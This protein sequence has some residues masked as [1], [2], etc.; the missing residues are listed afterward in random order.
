MKN[1]LLTISAIMLMGCQP[2]GNLTL[3]PKNIDYKHYYPK[4]FPIFTKNPSGK[5][6]I[7]YTLNTFNSLAQ[8]I[9]KVILI[10]N[11]VNR[12]DFTNYQA[13]YDM[14]M[15]LDK[16][17]RMYAY[18]HEVFES[19]RFLTGGAEYDFIIVDVSKEPKYRTSAYYTKKDT[20]NQLQK[21]HKGFEITILNIKDG[22][23]IFQSDQPVDPQELLKILD[24][25]ILEEERK[26]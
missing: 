17:P 3:F 16:E 21:D 8:G 25:K 9:T 23:V 5:T 7:K 6:E 22:K 4:N 24:E 20:T 11:Q 14:Y 15:V 26:K 19:M 10:E 1:I 18:Q 12:E 13:M 2:I